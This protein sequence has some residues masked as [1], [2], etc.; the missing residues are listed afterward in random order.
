MDLKSELQAY[1][2]GWKAVAEVQVDER[3]KASYKLR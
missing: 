1:Q 3:R 2:A